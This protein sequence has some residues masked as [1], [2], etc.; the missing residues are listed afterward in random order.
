MPEFGKKHFAVR[1]RFAEFEW[2]RGQLL[3]HCPSVPLA[4]LPPKRMFGPCN[5][6]CTFDSSNIGRFHPEFVDSRMQGL[7]Q[8]LTFVTKHR[9]LRTTEPLLLFLQANA[10]VRQH[11]DHPFIL[12]PSYCNCLVSVVLWAIRY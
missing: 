10:E 11:S 5:I 2:L 6:A 12:I 8:F 7:Q 1:R 3:S 9:M 4:A